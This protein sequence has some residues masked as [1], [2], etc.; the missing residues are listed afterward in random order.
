MLGLAT[1]PATL[2]TYQP[3][4]T[5][6]PAPT[7]T[8]TP[9]PSAPISAVAADGWQATMTTSAELSFAPVTVQRQGFDA[10]GA[11]A[12]ITDTL[13]T[14][15]RVR[16]PYP[17]HESLTADKVTLGE[18]IYSTDTIAGVTNNSA[19]TSPKPICAWTMEGRRLVGNGI[20]WEIV[21][22]HVN[23]RGRQFVPC[24]QVRA[25]DGTTTTARQT[26]S[27]TAL[28]THAEDANPIEVFK[29]TLDVTALA[30]GLVTLEARVPP[31]IGGAASVRSTGDT[32]V[33]R[34]FSPRYFYR[35][36]ARFASPP[37]AYVASTGNDTT[38]V[39]STNAATAAGTPFLTVAGA[40]TAMDNA[41]RGAPA[42]G[43]FMDG[44][45]I[46][47][48]DTVSIGSVAVTRPQNVAS[49]VIER[50]PGTA[51]GSAIV[52]WRANFRPRLG[53]GTLL[54]G[55]TEGAISFFDVTLNRT[56]AFTLIGESAAPL[57]C[58]FR[59]VALANSSATEFNNSNSV[60][61][62]YGVVNTG[63][64]ITWGRSTGIQ[65]RLIRGVTADLANNSLESWVTIGCNITRPS[66]LDS[67]DPSKGFINYINKW[68]NP[69]STGGVGAFTG[70]VSGA[71]FGPY[72]QVQNLVETTHAT[73][74][75]AGIRFANDGALG[76]LVHS[77][78]Y[79][80][81]HTG[82]G[83][84]GRQNQLY[85][86]ST[87]LRF[88]K[89]HLDRGNIYSQMNT[90]GDIFQ[91]DG[92]RLRQFAY[93][94]GI[95][96]QG[97]FSMFRVNGGVSEQKTYA[98]PGSLI[99]T[100]S[101]TVRQ[102]PLFVDYKGT[103]GSG[104]TPIAGAGG[105]NYVLQAGSPARGIVAVPLLRFD[106]AGNARPATNDAAGVYA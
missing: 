61:Y 51:R 24:V 98:G 70:A 21:A 106:L 75:T 28:S 22:F 85:D 73:P 39:W 78:N 90:K 19:E 20:D 8:P 52:T 11:A 50:A 66:G 4:A 2:A 15:K 53:V 46:R 23:G 40:M 57:Q 36:A 67:E 79:A 43:G 56:G 31:F 54:G 86:E 30:T 99:N 101:D 87:A 68:L 37:L 97:N 14:T 60:S 63:T 71:D 35:D 104:G 9:A 12:T 69:S 103:G 91:T 34:E 80:N 76:N 26:V 100:T 6:A 59:N 25:T 42:T 29:G 84:A 41:T 65:K 74:S 7:P 102:D 13:Y 49:P 38:G 94:H 10:T 77:V 92:T 33:A 81:T 72:V 88:H 16:Q 48:V 62:F 32:A 18:V 89:L 93:T 64:P 17:N 58:H 83:S 105:G 45:R 82:Y 44:C 1:S 5:P 3:W 27:T 96:A 55:L 95:G 47:I